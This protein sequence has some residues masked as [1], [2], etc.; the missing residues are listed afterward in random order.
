MKKLLTILALAVAVNLGAYAADVTLSDV[1]LCCGSCA[2]GVSAAV[3]KVDG[4]SA[5]ADQDAGTVKLTAANVATLQKAADAL[6][7]AGYFGKS[8]DPAVKIKSETGAKNVKVQSL[9]V[10]G[11]HMC[12]GKCVKAVNKILVDVPGVTGNTA[13]KGVKTFTVTGDFNDKD[14]FDAFQ[15]AGLTATEKPSAN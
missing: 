2:K 4:V 7:A 12:C 11:L 5:E 8:S 10:E 14:V 1:H 3:S 9:T 6:V 15:K 13:A